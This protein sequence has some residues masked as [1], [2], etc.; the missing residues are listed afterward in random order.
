MSRRDDTWRTRVWDV[1]VTIFCA[2]VFILFEETD[3]L[4]ARN[5]V[6]FRGKTTQKLD[7][8][9]EPANLPRRTEN[10]KTR[11]RLQQQQFHFP[12]QRDIKASLFRH[13]L[14]TIKV[15]RLPVFTQRRIVSARKNVNFV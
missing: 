9:I 13:H 8:I 4:D 5:L 12:R 10:S 14:A 15:F 2:S 3:A 7:E 6:L 1:S 11:G